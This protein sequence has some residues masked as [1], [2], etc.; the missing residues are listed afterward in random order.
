[1]NYR[2]AKEKDI[3]VL[4][5]LRKK[6]LVDE[7]SAPT[8]NIDEQLYDYFLKNLSDDSFISWVAEANEKIIATSGICFYHLPP[9]FSNPTG[10]NAYVTNMYT[11]NEYRCQGIASKLLEFVVNEAHKRDYKIVRLHA[12]NQAKSIYI[13]FG[14]SDSEGYMVMKING[15]QKN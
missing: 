9:S 15:I 10:K 12:S 11:K 14:F 2:R 8:S 6:Q 1:M 5:E 3:P 4:V 13:R 7:G